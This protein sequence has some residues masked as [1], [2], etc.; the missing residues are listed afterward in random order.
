MKE[1]NPLFFTWSKARSVKKRKSFGII[2][3]KI[4][5]YEVKV[6]S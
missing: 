4:M 2:S 5:K 3:R 1:I 6:R